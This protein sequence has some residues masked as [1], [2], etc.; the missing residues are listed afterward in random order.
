MEYSE[1]QIPKEIYKGFV[2][3]SKKPRVA[4]K[5]QWLAI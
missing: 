5:S 3:I 1:F 2:F 4:Y